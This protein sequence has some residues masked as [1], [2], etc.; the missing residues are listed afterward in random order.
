MILHLHELTQMKT[1]CN[2]ILVLMATQNLRSSVAQ[3]GI[4]IKSAEK[5]E[6]KTM[7]KEKGVS[8]GRDFRRN[9]FQ[10]IDDE[11]QLTPE[12]RRRERK[13]LSFD[14]VRIIQPSKYVRGCLYLGFH[15]GNISTTNLWNRSSI[16]APYVLVIMLFEIRYISNPLQLLILLS[17]DTS[18]HKNSGSTN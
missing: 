9:F 6:K 15:R 13:K 8:V 16:E 2:N 12:A 10:I 4:S 5:K 11:E 17:G 7:E 14:Y 18:R 1:L 3:V